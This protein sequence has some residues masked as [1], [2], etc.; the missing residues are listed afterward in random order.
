MILQRHGLKEDADRWA[1][2][3]LT[4]AKTK[5]REVTNGKA[6]SDFDPQML[7]GLKHRITAAWSKQSESGQAAVIIIGLCAEFYYQCLAFGYDIKISSDT[8]RDSITQAAEDM[9]DRELRKL[10]RRGKVW[11]SKLL[12][13][14]KSMQP[15]WHK[16]AQSR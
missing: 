8:L 14:L 3:A 10:H 6:L 12:S 9:K 7:G 1:E 13:K 11:L 5:H 16:Q 4:L 2:R 15:D